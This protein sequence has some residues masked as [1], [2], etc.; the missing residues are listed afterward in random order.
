MRVPTLQCFLSLSPCE[1]T[2]F[3]NGQLQQRSLDHS[4]MGLFALFFV[5]RYLFCVRCSYLPTHWARPTRLRHYRGTTPA[6]IKVGFPAVGRTGKIDWKNDLSIDVPVR[7]NLRP[8]TTAAGSV[9]TGLKSSAG[10][11]YLDFSSNKKTKKK[12]NNKHHCKT[13]KTLAPFRI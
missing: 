3:R 5:T 1:I 11:S 6:P 4:S 7:G 8:E 13:T 2:L 12:K 10:I 9:R